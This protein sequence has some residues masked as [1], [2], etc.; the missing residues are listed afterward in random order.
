M[1]EDHFHRDI[2]IPQH[3]HNE[4]EKPHGCC[5]VGAGD[6]ADSVT[7]TETPAARGEALVPLLS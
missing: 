3:R 5:C 7:P 2:I 4:V 6:E 1:L